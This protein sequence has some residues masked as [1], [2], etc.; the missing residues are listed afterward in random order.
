V[1]DILEQG[2]QIDFLLIAAAERR[3][4]LLPDDGEHRLVIELGVVEPVQQVNG[5]RARRGKAHADLARELRMTTGHEGGELFMTGLHEGHPV[6]R[7]VE[8]A[9]NAVDAVARISVDARDTP[10][11]KALQQEVG[12]S[13]G[14]A[15]SCGRG[16]G[17][18][19]AYP[20][21]FRAT[22]VPRCA[23][24]ALLRRRRVPRLRRRSV[25]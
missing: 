4:R 3:P 5:A 12:H 16:A 8:R 25:S 1:R 22:S 13:V 15:C 18:G 24:G 14:H 9:Q 6:G 23:A 17:A 11:G 20:P 21:F 7:A 10:L 19:P 2:D